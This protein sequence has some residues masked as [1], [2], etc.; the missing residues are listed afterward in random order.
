MLEQLKRFNA[1]NGNLE[2]LIAWSA[3]A[4]L[5]KTEFEAKGVET[6]EWLND[7]INR[8]TREIGVRRADT[9]E[10][11]LKELQNQKRGLETTAEKRA[12]LE[13]EIA[14]LTGQLAGTK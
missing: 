5:I 11:R 10:K 4:K 7:T 12:R 3:Y 8:L 6:P 14:N 9:L 2:E 13:Q 1:D